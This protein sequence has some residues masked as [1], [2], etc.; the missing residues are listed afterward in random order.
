MRRAVFMSCVV[1]VAV[2]ALS[3]TAVADE[4]RLKVTRSDEEPPP[5]REVSI[6]ADVFLLFTPVLRVTGEYKLHPKF[7]AAGFIGVGSEGT[8]SVTQAGVQLRGYA[9]G[10]F[11]EGMIYG[12]SVLSMN[13]ADEAAEG[14]APVDAGSGFAIGP[15]VGAKTISAN[16]FTGDF[17]LGFHRYLDQVEGGGYNNTAAIFQFNLGWSF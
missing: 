5:E 3:A 1:C 15:I 4:T 16:G 14:G 8:G 13:R 9:F 7:S 17:Q 2:C 10:D 12:L 11:Q 6:T